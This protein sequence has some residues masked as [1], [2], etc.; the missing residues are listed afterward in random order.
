MA[1]NEGRAHQLVGRALPHRLAGIALLGP[2]HGDVEHRGARDIVPVAERN[3][4]GRSR[5]A[6]T[7]LIAVEVG[8]DHQIGRIG[9]DL[10]VDPV[11]EKVP[12]AAS[13]IET[14]GVLW[15]NVREVEDLLV[16]RPRIGPFGRAEHVAIVT[17][18]VSCLAVV[19]D[20]RRD[21]G[22]GF[23][24]IRPVGSPLVAGMARGSHPDRAV[25]L[26]AEADRV[27]A[28]LVAADRQVGAEV[29]GIV[30]V[31][32]RLL[33]GKQFGPSG[34]P[35]RPGNTAAISI[36]ISITIAVSVTSTVTGKGR[37]LGAVAQDPR[38]SQLHVGVNPIAGFGIQT[39][40]AGRNR[41]ALKFG[42]LHRPVAFGSLI[43]R[44]V[45]EAPLESRIVVEREPG[46]A[47]HVGCSRADRDHLGQREAET[48]SG[49]V[50]LLAGDAQCGNAAKKKK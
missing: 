33:L 10:R 27:V 29:V 31:A 16:H 14:R 21:I 30:I 26:S 2:Q 50:P 44:T 25:V 46:P 7:V 47:V 20:T 41:I 15:C 42:D 3:L 37:E 40:L 23:V 19:L 38:G 13:G 35:G 32:V 12:A 4:L 48:G 36:T 17:T 34:V 24:G 43:G 49:I 9:A 11:L 28:G 39:G 5:I 6:V 1:A 18:A 45:G 22:I 8:S